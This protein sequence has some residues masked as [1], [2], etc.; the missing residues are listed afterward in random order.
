MLCYVDQITTFLG[1]VISFYDHDMVMKFYAAIN[2]Q[3]SR[4][5]TDILHNQK[6]ISHKQEFYL[7][8]NV[9]IILSVKTLLN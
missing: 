5:G 8:K 7:I 9:L 3:S 1:D 2:T 4:E 6:C